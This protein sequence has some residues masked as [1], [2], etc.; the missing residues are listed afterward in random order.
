MADRR[1]KRQKLEAMAQQHVSPNEARIAQRLLTEQD[2]GPIPDNPHG[3]VHFTKWRGR[4]IPLFT[5]NHFADDDVLQERMVAARSSPDK[6]L[7][8][9]TSPKKYAQMT[10]EEFWYQETG[11]YPEWKIDE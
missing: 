7:G 10:F 3:G 11:H 8:R 9:K 5:S 4:W 2:S 6:S 1:T